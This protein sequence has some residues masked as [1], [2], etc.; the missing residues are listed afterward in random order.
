MIMSKTLKILVAIAIC[1]ITLMTIKLNMPSKEE[2]E[3][4]V[5]LL[6]DVIRRP[7][8]KMTEQGLF[9]AVRFYQVNSI[10]AYVMYKPKF[11]EN[12]THDIVKRFFMLTPPQQQQ[13]KADYPTCAQFLN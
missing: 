9:E 2:K 3:R 5:A 12:Y 11:Q 10:P 13:A 1:L 6:C 8:T 7:E 4:H